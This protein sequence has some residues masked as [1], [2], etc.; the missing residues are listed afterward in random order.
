M[1]KCPICAEA[2]QDDAVKCKHCG[3]F[4]D[5]SRKPGPTEEKMVWYFRKPF[6]VIAVGSVG[7]LTLP[8][9]WWR[10]QT[11]RTWKIGLTVGILVLSWFL[12]QATLES[13]R[14]L[15]EYYPQIG[16]L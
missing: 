6:I 13:I 10:P 5:D 3:E 9:I 2:I 12:F 8:L 11:T 1:K 15:K 16:G 14:T 4:P 7:P